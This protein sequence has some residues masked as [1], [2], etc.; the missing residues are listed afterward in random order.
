MFS[1][2]WIN[3][4]IHI[5]VKIAEKN[6][7]NTS[8]ILNIDVPIVAVMGIGQNVQKFN[9]Q[10]YLREKFIDKGY[11]NRCLL[12]NAIMESG[13]PKRITSGFSSIEIF[14]IILS[15]LCYNIT[16]G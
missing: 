12:F 9:L 16:D 10:L 8:E 2:I 5:S 3:H 14:L 11:L 13:I 7:N 15:R 1:R 4:N 6:W